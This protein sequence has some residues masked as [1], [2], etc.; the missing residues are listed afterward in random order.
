[1][2]KDNMK[3]R[4]AE[5][6]N[7]IPREVVELLMNDDNEKFGIKEEKIDTNNIDESATNVHMVKHKESPS[8]S[9]ASKPKEPSASDIR[10]SFMD[11]TEEEIAS[12]YPDDDPEDFFASKEA[13]KKSQNELNDFVS[14]KKEAVRSR[15]KN[16]DDIN[17]D[18]E[19][20]HKSVE[21]DNMFNKKHSSR[22]RRGG[23]GAGIIIALIIF[24]VLAG[25][26]GY[27]YL[28]NQKDALKAET[29]AAEAEE[30]QAKYD[31]LKL[32]NVALQEEIEVLK[33]NL[34]LPEEEPEI[35]DTNADAPENTPADENTPP[36]TPA[37]ETSSTE[38]TVVSGDTFWSIAHKFYGNGAQFNKILQANN[39]T[40][41]SPL[42]E[43]DILIIPN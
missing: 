40:E 16:Y 1:M 33:G 41:N 4:R 32:Q 24:I 5:F 37:P 9:E 23:S 8:E 39:M 7:D 3:N 18:P 12:A 11:M 38:Y 21:L 27:Q 30:L 26:F 14:E 13:I 34:V 28:V 20:I 6:Y 25:F 29:I 2:D 43:G 17:E 35:T 36:E 10:L 15:R 42:K 19:R 22:R 31:E